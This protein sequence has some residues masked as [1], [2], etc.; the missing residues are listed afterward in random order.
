M[1]HRLGFRD[2]WEMLRPDEALHRDRA[3]IGHMQAVAR[4][5]RVCR[6]RCKSVAETRR[7]IE[8]AQKNCLGSG[9]KRP[10]FVHREEGLMK[11][12]AFLHHDPVA[13][14]HIS[15]RSGILRQFCDRHGIGTQLGRPR[16]LAVGISKTGFGTE[17]WAKWHASCKFARRSSSCNPERGKWSGQSAIDRSHDLICFEFVEADAAAADMAFATFEGTGQ[18][19][20]GVL[21]NPHIAVVLNCAAWSP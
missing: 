21:H 15:S 10:C 4:F 19:R 7:A 20:Q 11:R 17:M 18:A 12:R 3:K 8:Q 13:A 1:Q 16:E 5:Q 9:A 6:L 2:G 14:D